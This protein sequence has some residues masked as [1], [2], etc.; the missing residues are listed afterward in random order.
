MENIILFLNLNLVLVQE[1]LAIYIFSQGSIRK[2]HLGYP[3]NL[4]VVGALKRNRSDE[5][6][7][8]SHWSIHIKLSTAA[9]THCPVQS[10]PG[11]LTPLTNLIPI[12][13]TKGEKKVSF[14]RCAEILQVFFLGVGIRDE[15]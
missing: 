14:L 8:C 3:T 9:T 15:P 6:N 2:R 12:Y 13:V 1:L 7:F 10:Q 4:Q 11:S 5:D